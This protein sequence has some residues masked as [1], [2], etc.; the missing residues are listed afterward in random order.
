M[1]R[2]LRFGYGFVLMALLGIMPVAY[3][4]ESLDEQLRQP[5]NRELINQQR[6]VADQLLR[7]GERQAIQGDYDSAMR[8]R[9]REVEI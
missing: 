3:A 7:L 9:T 1:H 5:V 8:A 2:T 4:Q 6:D